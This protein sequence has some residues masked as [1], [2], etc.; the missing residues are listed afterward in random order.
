MVVRLL[1]SSEVLRTALS[2]NIRNVCVLIVVQTV[3]YISGQSS[4]PCYCENDPI[5]IQNMI[6][7]VTSRYA[8][9]YLPN[10]LKPDGLLIIKCVIQHYCSARCF[11]QPFWGPRHGNQNY[12]RLGTVTSTV[13]WGRTAIRQ[14]SCRERVL[15]IHLC[16][17]HSSAT[18]LC[19]QP[20]LFASYKRCC[21]TKV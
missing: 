7:F 5:L 13:R 2:A 16:R 17:V 1:W 14:I 19:Q 21:N 20:G 9:T 3:H 11:G 6:F 15:H 8:R 12:V 18:T 10:S 4:T